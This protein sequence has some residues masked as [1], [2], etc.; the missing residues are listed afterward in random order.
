MSR[1]HYKGIPKVR[2]VVVDKDNNL[3]IRGLG[4]RIANPVSISGTVSSGGTANSLSITGETHGDLLY[5]DGSDW[6]RLP[7]GEVGQFLQS[8]GAS[9]APSW[10]DDSNDV[11]NITS[12]GTSTVINVRDFIG[13]VTTTAYGQNWTPAFAAA[14]AA[15]ISAGI[16]VVYVPGHEDPYTVEKPG[17]QTPSIDLRGAT[18]FRLVGDGSSSKIKMQGS[19]MSGSW[20]MILISGDAEDVEIRDLWLDGNS[21]NLVNL[22]NGQHTHTL[23]IGG[24]NTLGYA[25]RVRVQNCTFTD[26]DGDGIA[27]IAK[28]AP[29]GTGDDVSSVTID[30]CSFIDCHRSGISNQRGLELIRITNCWFEGTSDQDIDFE[31]SG[32]P[33][34]RRYIIEGNH[35]IH[36]TDAACITLTGCG[37]ADPSDQNIFRN[38]YVIGG[39]VGGYNMRSMLFQGNYIITGSG[40]HQSAVKF[41]GTL[42]G[43][44]ISEN[45]IERASVTS[46]GT[47][48]D[49]G[50]NDSG[51][52]IAAV[53]A[54]DD[55]IQVNSHSLSTGDGPI[56]VSTV[57]GTLPG[58]L[59]TLTNYYAVF[60]DTNRIQLST[61]FANATAETPVVVDI[62]TT[63]T[64]VSG[65][66]TQRINHP[67]GVDIFGNKLYSYV[68]AD[69]NNSSVSLT[70][71]VNCSFK[72]NDVRN[73]SGVTIAN[74]VRFDTTAQMNVAVKGW[75]IS[76]NRISGDYD[77]SGTGRYTYGV[78]TSAVGKSITGI[79]VNNN[80]FQGTANRIRW[81]KSST[82]GSSYGDIPMAIGN[83]GSGVDFAEMTN[84]SGVLT[85]G[86]AQSQAYYISVGVPT[87]SGIVASIC[88]NRAGVSGTLLYVNT[89][90][91][92]GWYPFA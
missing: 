69:G 39:T 26:M 86:N 9:A 81:A 83:M 3:S 5:F 31:P 12:S 89:N 87:F 13:L 14:K 21:S 16:D 51:T 22:D 61:S 70:N 58:G 23:Q 50:S 52:V 19:G 65:T 60:Y 59:A 46:S 11:F 48:L 20:S 33:G 55:Y 62:L 28:S 10:A 37:G 41:R 56:Q 85:G 84:V 68:G 64:M 80:T 4:P 88:Q 79:R 73:Y 90:S 53:S 7:A 36:T 71:G 92:T 24:G 76:G 74:A 77:T 63:G 82:P 75:D 35:V 40:T 91:S 18:N 29:F 25:K 34:P 54:D 43:V 44:R 32:T 8:F 45:Y 72:D 1:D 49:L 38:N 17:S 67:K 27:F 78:T 6:V 57:S 66:I 30:H 15:A 42:D 47:V 2:D